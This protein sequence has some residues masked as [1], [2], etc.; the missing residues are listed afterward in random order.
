[1]KKG[2]L[3]LM[4]CLS[5]WSIFN[6]NHNSNEEELNSLVRYK[7]ESINKTWYVVNYINNPFFYFRF[8]SPKYTKIFFIRIEELIMDEIFKPIDNVLL[9]TT[10]PNSKDLEAIRTG[11]VNLKN[12]CD[13]LNISIRMHYTQKELA[14]FIHSYYSKDE[15]K[16]LNYKND[17]L[18]NFSE[19]MA[20]M[21]FENDLRSIH[22]NQ[23][24]MDSLVFKFQ[25]KLEYE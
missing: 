4:V 21:D 23:I 13:Y 5:I 1:M 15:V 3:F 14:D 2:F 10:E 16:L 12:I 20:F 11:L 22:F 25:L 19:D 8:H 7:I 9:N 6:L 18:N 17:F 24:E